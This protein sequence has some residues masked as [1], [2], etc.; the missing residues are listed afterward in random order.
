M[1]TAEYDYDIEVQREEAWE[2][3]IERGMQR[4]I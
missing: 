1:F 3:G 4:G 2:L